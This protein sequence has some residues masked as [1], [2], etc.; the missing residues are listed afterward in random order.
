MGVTSSSSARLAHGELFEVAGMGVAEAA[1]T[2]SSRVSGGLVVLNRLGW[3]G[4]VRL[5]IGGWSIASRM[6]SSASSVV[7]EDLVEANQVGGGDHAD[8]PAVV[9]DHAQHVA[10]ASRP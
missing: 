3:R 8:E 1:A 7:A 2:I 10:V 6:R 5:V 4:P 9:V